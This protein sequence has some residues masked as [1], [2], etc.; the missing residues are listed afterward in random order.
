M[1]LLLSAAALG[2]ALGAS[3]ASALVVQDNGAYT[4]SYDETTSL[5]YLS[6][7]F[8]SSNDTYGFSWNLDSGIQAISE[9]GSTVNAFSLPDFVLSA[10]SGYVLGGN[11]SAFLGNLVFNQLGAAA[12]TGATVSAM[13]SVDGGPA[14]AFGGPLDQVITASSGN[15]TSGYFSVETSQNFGNFS[16]LSVSAVTLTLSAE[17]GTFA[18]V[19]S[20][21]QNKLEVSFQAV[22]VPEPETYAMLLSG[23]AALA[24]VARRRRR[25]D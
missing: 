10:N 5:G 22:P 17:G 18:S 12:S 15:F 23:L 2:L 14:I 9:G 13:I 16:S 11:V 4:L 8:S 21:P 20:Q 25:C 6:S 19:L 3:S 24:W 1:K 7:W